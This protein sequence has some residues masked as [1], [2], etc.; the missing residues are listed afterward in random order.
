MTSKSTIHARFNPTQRVD[1]RLHQAQA[2]APTE[3]SNPRSRITNDI[4]G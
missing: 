3:S 4:L 1:L 2:E